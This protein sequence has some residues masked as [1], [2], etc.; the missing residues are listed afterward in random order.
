MAEDESNATM[1]NDV[2][3]LSVLSFLLASG[4]QA[5][6]V[7]PNYVKPQNSLLP[8]HNSPGSTAANAVTV[9]L[10]HW[11]TGFNDPLLVAV[12]EDA[13]D[14][15]WNLR[16]AVGRVERARAAASGEGAKLLPTMDL[17]MSA[18]ANR[19]SLNG[20]L[21]TIAGDAPGFR[22]SFEEY[23]IGP[24][25]SWEIDLFGGQRRAATAARSDA[26]AAEADHAAIRV[27]VAGDAADAYLQI[28]GLQARIEIA[29]EQIAAQER[30]L[31]LLHEQYDA[32]SATRREI[33]Q[34]V[35]VLEQARA[36]IPPLRIALEQQLNRLDVL[37]AAQPGAFRS[38]SDVSSGVPDIPAM[39][40]DSSPDDI[41]RRR[42]DVV[43][44]EQRLVAANERIGVAISGY[45]PKLSLLGALGVDSLT[46]GSLF[47]G[48]AFYAGGSGALRWRIFDFGKVNAEIMAA[49]GAEAE[50][51]ANYRQAVLNA[52]EDVENSI[53]AL[54]QTQVR[55]NQI[56]NQVHAL[57]QART[58]SEQA[59]R[60]GAIPLTDVLIADTQLLSA[61]DQLQTER[62]NTARA[63]VGVYRALGGGWTLP[64]QSE[65]TA[66]TDKRSV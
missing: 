51:L 6:M 48:S 25:A 43:A 47:T 52:V 34:A 23:G 57:V 42:P 11:W 14:K 8:L 18:S 29:S 22:R 4:L 49:R 40:R 36:T 41:L 50:A 32:G 24:S 33:A 62:T 17:G 12:V 45:Y 16:A 30:L 3:R 60:A 31:A 7:G 59:Y 9:P 13:L 19:Q 56:Q 5:C 38:R 28:R 35:A 46:T 55:V 2:G 64:S 27:I 21:G 58:L 39:Q 61:R 1:R 20:L 53:V 15:N 10:D 54:V 26:A 37:V 65:G 63:A 66:A 44:A